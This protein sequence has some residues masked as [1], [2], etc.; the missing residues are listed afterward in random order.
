MRYKLLSALIL[1]SIVS[2]NFNLVA[3]TPKNRTE[4]LRTV[5]RCMSRPTPSDCSVDTIDDALGYLINLYNHGNRSLLRP[6]LDAGPRSDG[7]FGE[8]LGDLYSNVLSKHPRTF[9]ASIR[10]RPLKQQRHFCW[11][12]G[13]TDGSGMGTQMLRD[14]RHS[15][16]VISSRRADPLSSVARIC[17]ANVNRAN[18]SNGR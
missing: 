10:S 8:A 1:L 4:A 12:A 6:L 18:A 14:V 9:L 3:K 11:M 2:L 17:L 15:L 5:R 16:R 7:A 13:V